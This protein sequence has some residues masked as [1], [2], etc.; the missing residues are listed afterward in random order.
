MGGWKGISMP[1][2]IF[3]IKRRL[4]AFSIGCVALLALCVMNAATLPAEEKKLPTEPGEPININA[5]RLVSNTTQRTAEFLGN[6]KVVQGTT[7]ITA[8]RLKLAYK[9]NSADPA[10]AGAESIDTIEATG[11][12]RIAL[13]N[14]VAVGEKAVYTTSDRKLVISGPGAQITSGPDVIEGS[15]I[16]FHRDSGKVEM[17]GQVKATI[18][19]DQ[20]GLN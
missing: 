5:D 14:R 17:V 20:R 19:S 9:G 7:T 13:D 10:Q 12:V 18:R 6:V 16:T 1:G 3:D 11:H 4:N 8:D 15:T 2:S